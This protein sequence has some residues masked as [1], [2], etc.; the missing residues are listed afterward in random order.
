MFDNETISH[1]L[2]DLSPEGLTYY[3][4]I[5]QNLFFATLS[6]KK[7]ERKFRSETRGHKGINPDH[8]NDNVFRYQTLFKNPDKL[9]EYFGEIPFLN[10]A[11]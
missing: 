2:K 4:A 11:N 3:Q 1:R 7:N 10:G 9:K 5:L 6:T 8:G